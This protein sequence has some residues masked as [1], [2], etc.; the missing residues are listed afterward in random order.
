MADVLYEFKS[1]AE[2]H[3][4]GEE[5]LSWMDPDSDNLQKDAG[6]S[7][8]SEQW[9]LCGKC[10]AIAHNGDKHLFRDTG[11]RFTSRGEEIRHSLSPDIERPHVVSASG[12]ET[13]PAKQIYL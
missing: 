3:P 8:A 5:Y 7:I 4:C 11:G 12:T 6:G 13:V 2:K 9:V 1:V 10:L